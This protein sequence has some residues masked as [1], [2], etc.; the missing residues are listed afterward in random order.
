MKNFNSLVSGL[1]LFCIMAATPVMAIDIKFNQVAD[2]V[3]AFIGPTTNRTPENLGL[4]NNIG[5]VVTDEGAVLIDSGA[6]IPSA[7]ALK[8]AVALVTSQ[9]IVAVI[10]TGSQDHRWLGNGYFAEQGAKIFALDKT[11][12]TQKSQSQE[13]LQRMAN[14]SEIFQSTKA[15]TA[16]EKLVGDEAIITVGSVDFELK[17]LGNAH[18]PGDAVVWLPK[19]KVLFSGDLIYV[20]RMLGVLPYSDVASWQKAFHMAEKLPAKFIVPGHG[21]VS[22]WNKARKDTGHYLDKL[23]NVMSVAADDM[24]GVD[25]AVQ[26]NKDWPEFKHLIHYDSWHKMI[27]SRTYLQYENGL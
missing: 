17:F 25:Q 8:K 19:Q 7:K 1:F 3:Y 11:V 24:V 20:D 12:A 21:A 14:V 22:D 16:T 5:L 10:N 13:L 23:V 27:L 4:N 15:V 18:F 26:D 6:G 9:P 2:N